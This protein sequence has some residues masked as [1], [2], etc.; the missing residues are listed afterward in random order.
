[1]KIRKYY[2]HCVKNTKY[3]HSLISLKLMIGLREVLGERRFFNGG[4]GGNLIKVFKDSCVYLVL[5]IT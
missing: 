1:M 2:I 5:S 4:G 3:K